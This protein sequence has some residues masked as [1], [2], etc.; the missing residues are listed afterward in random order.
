MEKIKIPRPPDPLG[1]TLFDAIFGSD[2]KEGEIDVGPEKA[3]EVGD[4]IKGLFTL[5]TKLTELGEA[6]KESNT[7]LREANKLGGTLKESNELLKKSNKLIP[8]VNKKLEELE[9]K[10]KL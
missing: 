5:S 9:E 10:L 7:L 4:N 8:Q 6:L 2:K 3:R 1:G